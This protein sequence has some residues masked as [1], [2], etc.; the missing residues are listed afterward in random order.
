[1]KIEKYIKKGEIQRHSFEFLFTLIL[2]VI[3]YF[4]YS[5]IYGQQENIV[6]ADPHTLIESLSE[7][8]GKDLK[9]YTMEE[10]YSI[11]RTLAKD[12]SHSEVCLAFAN[13]YSKRCVE[14]GLQEIIKQYGMHKGDKLLS[15]LAE[16]YIIN[17]LDSISF[18]SL[19]VYAPTFKDTQYQ[20]TLI[21][22]LEFEAMDRG[23]LEVTKVFKLDMDDDFADYI[24]EL[25]IDQ[26][27]DMNLSVIRDLLPYYKGT[28]FYTEVQTGFF[29]KLDERMLNAETHYYTHVSDKMSG[30]D[31]KLKK[32]VTVFYNELFASSTK[33]LMTKFKSKKERNQAFVK[34]WSELI[35]KKHYIT[36]FGKAVSE[37]KSSYLKEIDSVWR[38]A[39]INSVKY[40]LSTAPNI[41]IKPDIV[42]FEKTLSAKSKESA[43]HVASKAMDIISLTGCIGW[44][45]QGLCF[46]ADIG[47]SMLTED[48]EEYFVESQVVITLNQ[49]TKETEKY[50]QQIEKENNQIVKKIKLS[51]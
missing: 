13:E 32:D 5:T 33:T 4:S 38:D 43:I 22:Y 42:A 1:M 44:T 36:K 2:C 12:N 10:L 20:D 30:V 29:D 37:A 24:P 21:E 14:G 15:Y 25:V 47:Y 19:L 51:L 8:K 46:V 28:E 3:I 26:L 17:E 27:G 35:N 39:G 18:D 7:D 31:D 48:Q 49:L 45:I 34:K 6:E 41:K 11:Y 9:D 50:F 23:A 16:K 40:S